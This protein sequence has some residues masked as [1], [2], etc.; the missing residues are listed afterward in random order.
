[1]GGGG[2][3]NSSRRELH[4][5]SSERKEGQRLRKISK[6][7]RRRHEAR[8]G[9]HTN[10]SVWLEKRETRQK[11]A[12]IRKSNKKSEIR[13]RREKQV[14]GRKGSG[15]MESFERPVESEAKKGKR[16]RL[17]QVNTEATCKLEE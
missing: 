3:G 7:R 2:G 14:Q 4:K 9:K 10:L 1:V 17:P 8:G 5:Q 11:T 16:I 12:Q 15:G 6:T 13:S